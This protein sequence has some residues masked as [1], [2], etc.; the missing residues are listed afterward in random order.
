MKKILIIEDNKDLAEA[1]EDLLKL[2]NYK[3]LKASNMEE[4]INLALRELPDLIICNISLPR[5]HEG[6]AI[7]QAL[8]DN[9]STSSIPII[10]SSGRAMRIDIE[11]GRKLGKEYL[12]KPYSFQELREAI[13]R[14]LD[15]PI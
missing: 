5:D 8:A 12:V 3:T 14:N 2:E 11:Q 6:I 15:E 9:P 7:A 13:R 10:F 4:G 1:L